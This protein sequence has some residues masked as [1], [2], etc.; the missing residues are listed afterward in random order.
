M[1]ERFDALIRT[2]LETGEKSFHEAVPSDF[3]P[4]DGRRTMFVQCLE[5]LEK[6]YPVRVDITGEQAALID[7]GLVPNG[8]VLINGRVCRTEVGPT[9]QPGTVRLTFS[10]P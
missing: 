10:R 9:V 3:G 4:P 1:P 5:A 7:M 8:G 6:A 2:V